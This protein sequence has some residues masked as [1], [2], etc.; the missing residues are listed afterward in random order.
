MKKIILFSAF[1]ILT[2]FFISSCGESKK[3]E[4]QDTPQQEEQVIDQ[5]SSQE[6]ETSLPASETAEEETVMGDAPVAK[7]PEGKQEP[8][9]VEVSKAPMKYQIIVLDDVV[10]G[11]YRKLNKSEADK[12]K[13]KG[14]VLAVKGDNGQIYFVYTQ[15]GSF[16]GKRLA[17]HAD[18]EF[19]AI[20]GKVKKQYGMNI[21]I[22]EKIEPF[23]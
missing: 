17:K 1:A 11:N 18:S 8:K 7:E 14:R 15:G 4:P 13:G 3:D 2:L 23:K 10:T 19:I 16:A 6:A 12:L 9:E 21:I 20:T 22:A 5:G